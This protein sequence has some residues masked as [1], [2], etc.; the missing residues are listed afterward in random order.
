MLIA[1]VLGLVVARASSV[2]VVAVGEPVD[3]SVP[4]HAGGGSTACAA[5]IALDHGGGSGENWGVMVP[6][7]SFAAHPRSR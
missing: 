7:V 4:A 6:L 3:R 1:I 5:R 2:G